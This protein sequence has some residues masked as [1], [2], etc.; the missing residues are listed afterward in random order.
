VIDAGELQCKADQ[1]LERDSAGDWS[2]MMELGAT[3]CLPRS[4][5]CLVPGRSVPAR[6]LGL[7]GRSARKSCGWRAGKRRAPR[8]KK[9][10]VAFAGAHN[11][12]QK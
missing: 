8:C 4:P 12:K 2:A 9:Q 10:V 1:L 6:K 5:Q 7:A 3:I 11:I